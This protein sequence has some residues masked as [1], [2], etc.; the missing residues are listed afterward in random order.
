MQ[1]L[2]I[3]FLDVVED[4]VDEDTKEEDFERYCWRVLRTYLHPL[5]RG[6]QPAATFPNPTLSSSPS[7]GFLAAQTKMHHHRLNCVFNLSDN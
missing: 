7:S 1:V 6:Q 3:V 4:I 5:P 2:K